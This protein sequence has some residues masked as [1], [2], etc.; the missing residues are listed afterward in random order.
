[1]NLTNV[2]NFCLS[3]P[4]V[5]EDMPFDQETL[6]FRIHQKIFALLNINGEPLKINLKCDPDY[7]LY[8]RDRYS[9]SITAGFH[10]NKKHWN[11]VLLESDEYHTPFLKDMILHAYHLVIL[12]LGKGVRLDILKKIATEGIEFRLPPP[13]EDWG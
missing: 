5:S 9:E 3:L 11:T 13:L 12:G 4:Y 8:L 6:V 7:A 10:M 1:M 2:R